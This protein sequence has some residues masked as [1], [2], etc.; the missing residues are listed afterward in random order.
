MRNTVAKKRAGQQDVDSSYLFANSLHVFQRPSRRGL[1][2]KE[3]KPVNSGRSPSPHRPSR[4]MMTPT[5]IYLDKA[6]TNS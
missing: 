6:D 2:K 3:L 5:G 1:A 4:R